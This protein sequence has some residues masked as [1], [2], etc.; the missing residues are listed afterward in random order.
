MCL[1][2]GT[3]GVITRTTGCTLCTVQALRLGKH[4][5]CIRVAVVVI[6]PRVRC[7]WFL[8]TATPTVLQHS[9]T[10]WLLAAFPIAQR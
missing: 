9:V 5:A 10:V 2:S 6:G 4:A 8:H 1:I 3:Q 7:G